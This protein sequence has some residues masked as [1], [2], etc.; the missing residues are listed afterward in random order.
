MKECKELKEPFKACIKNPRIPNKITSRRERRILHREPKY[1]I[2][3]E[4][5]DPCLLIGIS[6]SI[7]A[8]L[9]EHFWVRRPEVAFGDVSF[10][11]KT[12]DEGAKAEED[13]PMC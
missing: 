9:E 10:V 6:Q 11:Q 12:I 3:I 13:T 7:I 2:H 1:H 4:T 8:E 5:D